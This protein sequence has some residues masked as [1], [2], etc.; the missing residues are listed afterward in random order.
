MFIALWTQLGMNHLGKLC[1][2]LF[3]LALLQKNRLILL[4]LS[5]SSFLE[6]EIR[7]LHKKFN[8]PSYYLGYLH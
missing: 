1:G 8:D 2:N 5:Y 6:L 3:N 7:Q 4:G